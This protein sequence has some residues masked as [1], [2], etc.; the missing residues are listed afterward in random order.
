M[1]QRSA[2]VLAAIKTA[3]SIM[4]AEAEE[5]FKR[6]FRN[7]GFED[8]SIEK[9]APRKRLSRADKKA[10]GRSR[11]ILVQSGALRNGIVRSRINAYRYKVTS[12]LPYSAI[13]NYGLP[14]RAWGKHSFT[15]PQRRF[16]GVS[17]M[18]I[19]RNVRTFKKHITNALHI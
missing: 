12:D 8:N 6:S 9:W 10:K 17:Q 14:G 5:H 15:M 7:Q 13:H 1:D 16:I 4:A 3:M 11:A 19:K 18:L 2:K